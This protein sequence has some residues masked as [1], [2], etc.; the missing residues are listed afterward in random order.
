MKEEIDQNDKNS[1]EFIQEIEN[2]RIEI[3]NNRHDATTNS[4]EV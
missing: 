3:N 4:M 1:N 2:I